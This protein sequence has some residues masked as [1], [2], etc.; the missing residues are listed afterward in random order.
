MIANIA[1]EAS[2]RLDRYKYLYRNDVYLYRREGITGF[3]Y[4]VVRL[5]NHT[6]RVLVKAKDHRTMRLG[7]IWKSTLD[8]LSFNP[9]I[10][11]PGEGISK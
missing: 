1:Y 11:F 8:G 2:D 4:E 10:E 5:L 6:A 9:A 7:Y 3:L